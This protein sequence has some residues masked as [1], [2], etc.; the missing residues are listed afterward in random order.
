MTWGNALALHALWALIPLAGLFFFLAARR[1]RRLR[2][3]LDEDA[4]ARLCPERWRE[5][6]RTKT[7]LRLL[8]CALAIVALA[9]PQWG[10]HWEEVRRRGLDILVVL[11]TSNSMRAT[12]LK[13]NRLQQATWGLRDLVKRL[14]GDRIGLVAFAG[15]SFLECPLTIDYAAF[16]L[17]LD[18]VYPG[19]IPRGGTAIAPALGT[20][21]ENFGAGGE[22]DRVIILITDGEDHEGDLERVIGTLK[23]KHVRVFAVGVGTT[24]GEIIPAAEGEGGAFLKDAS[25]NVVK[26]ALREAVLERIAV[27]TGGMYV[28]AAPGDFGLDRIFNEGI[29]ALKRDERES[30][31][32]RAAEERFPWFLGAALVLL[33]LECLLG[34]RRRGKAAGVRPG[35][36]LPLACLLLAAA[37]LPASPAAAGEARREMREGVG[38]FEGKRYEEAAGKFA[39]AARKAADEGLDPAAAHY[40]RASALLKAGKGAAAAAALTEALRSTDPALQEQAHYNRGNALAK[41]AEALE[42]QGDLGGAVALLEEA[43]GMYEGAMRL[44]PKD[45]DPKVNHEVVARKKAQLE[46]RKKEQEKKQEKNRDQDDR[47]KDQKKSEG[48]RKEEERKQGEKQEGKQEEQPGKEQ[49]REQ[50]AGKKG[51]E[52]QM[53]PEE[54][55]LL[56]E[57]MRQQ[58]T[59]QRNQLRRYLGKPVRV[60]KDW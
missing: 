3:L 30:K 18:D 12:D 40:N 22:A 26:S 1:E 33:A 14:N 45:E 24:E 5:R 47:K 37:L 28:R 31:M 36:A 42:Q 49:G 39:E 7:I 2:L 56:L 4:A 44:D 19:I 48:E 17:M 41:A 60:D 8:A 23:E 20:A 15:S 54:A 58:E 43:L 9:R 46:E 38:L 10:F 29:A 32:I 35:R 13:P 16:S 57:A 34:D 6:A 11:D 50:Q 52:K 59:S 55:R 25:G 53:S 21:L 51:Q 27:A